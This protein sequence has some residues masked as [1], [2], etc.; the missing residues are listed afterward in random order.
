MCR[1]REKSLVESVLISIRLRFHCHVFIAFK[2]AFSAIVKST[3]MF[4]YSYV[5]VNIMMLRI[6]SLDDDQGPFIYGVL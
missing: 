4:C 3:A 5:E 6:Q 1:R 2:N